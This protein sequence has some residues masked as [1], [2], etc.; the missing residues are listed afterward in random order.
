MLALG[1]SNRGLGRR[2][3]TW[4]DTRRTCAVK[5]KIRVPM[6][7]NLWVIFA[8]S[9]QHTSPGHTA[10]RRRRIEN[11]DDVLYRPLRSA[12]RRH[13]LRPAA[14]ILPQP[15]SGCLGASR[16][17]AAR[18]PQFCAVPRV[19]R[20]FADP[21]SHKAARLARVPKRPSAAGK[22]DPEYSG[23]TPLVR[24]GQVTHRGDREMVGEV[25]SEPTP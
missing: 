7:E 9:G 5:R 24:T 21:V 17:L 22:I 1:G 2:A 19:R 16:R 14:A 4:R 11:G 3:T 25:V 12:S 23:D 20:L 8:C 15:A 6:H 13:V 18:K 10:S